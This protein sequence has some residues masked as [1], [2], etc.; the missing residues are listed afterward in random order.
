VQSAGWGNGH[1]G[2]RL[3]GSD[4][5]R[6]ETTYSGDDNVPAMGRVPR[7]PAGANGPVDPLR[8]QGAV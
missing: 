5:S 2:C 6:P 1:R 7:R 3:G 8:Q 4:K